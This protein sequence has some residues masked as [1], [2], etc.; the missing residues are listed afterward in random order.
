MP[1]KLLQQSAYCTFK[2][3]VCYCTDSVGNIRPFT[4]P[5]T[6]DIVHRAMSQFLLTQ[7]TLIMAH[8]NKGH[9]E[10]E[11]IHQDA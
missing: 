10:K 7:T 1:V 3:V 2:L 9:L 11:G 6:G 5:G 8:Q 4:L